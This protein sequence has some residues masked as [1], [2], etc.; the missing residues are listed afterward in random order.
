MLVFELVAEGRTVW[1]GELQPSRVA[2]QRVGQSVQVDERAEEELELATGQ[3]AV[4]PT[5]E[6]VSEVAQLARQWADS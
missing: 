3:A 4:A 2:R 5:T 6:A 1:V